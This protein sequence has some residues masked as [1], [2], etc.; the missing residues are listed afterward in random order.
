MASGE[1]DP[2]TIARKV[3]VA[4]VW[5]TVAFVVASYFLIY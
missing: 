5:G 4:T 3:F 1:Y 2:Q